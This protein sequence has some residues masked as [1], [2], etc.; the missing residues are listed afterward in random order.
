MF[1]NVVFYLSVEPGVVASYCLNIQWHITDWCPEV[2]SRYS[3]HC[4][5]FGLGDVKLLTVVLSLLGGKVLYRLTMASIFTSH[6]PI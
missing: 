3:I 4:I 5:Q 1:S 2:C 6:R